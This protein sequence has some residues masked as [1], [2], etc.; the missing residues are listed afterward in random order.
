MPQNAATRAQ[1][2]G[3]NTVVLWAAASAK[4][5]PSAYW[6]TYRQWLTLGAQV[7]KGEK[8]TAVVFYKPLDYVEENQETGEQ[9]L[10]QRMVLR[11]YAVFNA[12]QV[13][14]WEAPEIVRPSQAQVLVTVEDLVTKTGAR[15]EHGASSC[16]Y[17][18]ATDTIHMV[19][20]DRFENGPTSTATEAYYATL[21]HELIH[22]TGH[23]SR[24]K[25]DLKNRFGTEAY[26]MEELVA[27]LG[28]AF[29]CS[30]IGVSVL[31]R[32]DHAAYMARWLRVLR[33][34]KGAVF[35]AAHGARVAAAVV[36]AAGSNGGFLQSASSQD[37]AE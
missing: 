6:S 30:H 1:Y 7:R 11:S 20:R 13:E 35:Q 37:A 36:L 4:S 29:L 9:K 25:R 21:L 17:R 15:I 34:D 26:A 16:F 32:P 19:D 12:S 18:P 31:P 22:W 27:E 28:A 14:G 23:E 24:L 10:R 33:A 8:A 5:Y 3:I 2:R